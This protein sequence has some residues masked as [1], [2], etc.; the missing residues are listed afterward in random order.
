MAETFRY[1]QWWK[2][3]STMYNRNAL[4]DNHPQSLPSLWDKQYGESMPISVRVELGVP[5]PHPRIN[6]QEPIMYP[7]E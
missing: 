7:E 6:S 2:S 1:T 5:P 3:G 4:Q